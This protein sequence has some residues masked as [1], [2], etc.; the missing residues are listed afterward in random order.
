MTQ[1][2][3]I[4]L[5]PEGLA[6]G[7]TGAISRTELFSSFP[8][9]GIWFVLVAYWAGDHLLPVTL[10][11]RLLWLVARRYLEWAPE[12]GFKVNWDWV[13]V[14]NKGPEPVSAA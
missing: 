13:G 3:E 14:S 6:R 5:D 12:K 4:T 1:V 7:F 9:A 2:A 11:T 8:E 10:L